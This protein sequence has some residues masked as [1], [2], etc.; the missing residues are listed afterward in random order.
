MKTI[1]RSAA[2]ALFLIFMIT[3]TT[4]AR[5]ALEI[6]LTAEKTE[7]KLG[8]PVVV[9]VS[10]TNK[11]QE[12]VNLSPELGPEA[13]FLQYHITNPD[14][15]E[16]AFSPA[17]VADRAD[18]ITLRMNETATG[19]A[20]I[21]YGGNGYSFPKAGKYGV[22]ARYKNSRST[23]L[24]IRVLAPA[25]DAER[26]QASMI[27]DH[28]EVGLF[29]MLEGGDEL[30]DAKKQID[31][32]TGKHP[33]SILTHY[34]RYAVAKNLSVPAR[35]FVSKKPRAADLPRSIEMLQGLKDKDFQFYYQSKANSTLAA[36]LS[37]LNRKD[38][39]RKVLQDFRK[40]LEGMDKLR[41]YYLKDIDEELDKMK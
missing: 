11:G 30:A 6:R 20:R 10:V 27:L 15:K 19:A 37:K 22:V 13:D 38:D 24:E 21:F 40:K 7:F 31:A 29:L 5:S 17:F 33:T 36:S 1:H 32:L 26:E 12:P 9:L 35:N 14:G 23:P 8:E 34:V 3:M 39:A 28:H 41:P 16:T 18:F 25:N 2:I 4:D